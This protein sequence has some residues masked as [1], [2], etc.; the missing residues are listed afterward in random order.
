MRETFKDM[1]W[2]WQQGAV[3]GSFDNCLSG[4]IPNKCI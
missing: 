4:T 1:D 3:K 2:G